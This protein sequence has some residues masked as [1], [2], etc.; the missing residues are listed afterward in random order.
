M[1]AGAVASSSRSAADAGA[2]VLREGGNAVDAGIAA[3][4]VSAVTHP[5]IVSL[6]GGGFITVWPPGGRPVTIDGYGEMPGRGAPPDRRGRGGIEVHLGYGG[7]VTTIVGYGSVATPG[8]LAALGLASARYGRV[9][10]NLVVGPAFEHARDGFP[11]PD[12]S[13]HYLESSHQLVYGW[14]P[15]SFAALHDA[16]GR[17]LEAGE[18]V[19]IPTLADSL[20]IIADEGVDA[21]YRGELG[22][23]IAEDSQRHDGLLT[24]EDLEAYRPIVRPA[25]EVEMGG[26]RLATN[27][28]PAVGGAV[29][30]VMLRLMKGRP[31]DRWTPDELAYWIRVQEAVFGYR[32]RQLDLSL[33]P[34]RDVRRFLEETTYSGFLQAVTSPSTVHTSAVDVEGLACSV[35]ISTGYGSGVMPPGTGLWMNNFLG[36]LELNR[37]GFHAW[38]TGARLASNMAPSAGRR[39]DGAV[40]AI[41]TPG[42]DRITTA[43]L[44]TLVNFVQLGLTLPDAVAHPR[45]H[46]EWQGEDEGIRV[47]YEAG[48]RVDELDV[49]QRRFGEPSMFFGGVCAAL[50]DPAGGFLV[51]SDPRR[52]GGV[53][54]WEGKD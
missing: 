20:R 39:R 14:H 12:S 51:A 10:W 15:E 18:T 22:R 48:L 42:A 33:E 53:A 19:R 4:L 37:R 8:A 35:S 25:L 3:L 23:L 54:I 36:E 40:L 16:S 47:A 32:R 44:Q 17:L 24:R 41:G 50:R 45:L 29:L 31:S 52:A 9:P 2:R 6:G 1:T 5:A 46:V 11:L 13:R 21:V 34:E 28:P 30:A 7:G 49:P 27:P 43:L 26:W 38:P